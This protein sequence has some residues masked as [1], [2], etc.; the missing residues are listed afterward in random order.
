MTK[1]TKKDYEEEIDNIF[2]RYENDTKQPPTQKNIEEWLSER[3]N[4]PITQQQKQIINLMLSRNLRRETPSHTR[5]GKPIK[6]YH[7][8]HVSWN[9]DKVNYLT[10]HSLKESRIM[11]SSQHTSRGIYDKWRREN[12]KLRK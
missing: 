6:A 5:K 1:R 7:K 8:S 3:H 10:S 2:D 9:Y 4:Q 12:K 11:F